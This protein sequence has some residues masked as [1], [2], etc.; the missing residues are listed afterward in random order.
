MQGEREALG[1]GGI[2]AR[3]VVL[4][5]RPSGWPTLDN[6]RLEE[7]TPSPVPTGGLLL[8][9]R[10]LSLD[11]YMRMRMDEHSPYAGS[12]GGRGDHARFRRSPT[13]CAP[14]TRTT[15]R[16]TLCWLRPAGS[17]TRCPMALACGNW[18]RRWPR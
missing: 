18:T 15:P 7:F 9:V 4:A 13:C 10:Y 17:A 12:V 3:R 8:R 2:T 16:G 6:F 5:G 11:P 1:R 14:S